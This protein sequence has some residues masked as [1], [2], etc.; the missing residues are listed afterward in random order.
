MVVSNRPFLHVVSLTTYLTAS[1]L[2]LYLPL[3][4]DIALLR[5]RMPGGFRKGLYEVL[6]LGWAGTEK[7]I[8]YLEKGIAVMAVTVLPI[9]VSVHTVASYVFS[10]TVQPMWH[11][12]I[13]GPYFVAGAIFSWGSPPSSWPWLY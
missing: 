11:S 3:I 2:Y 1:S 4:P 13:F 8:H 12:S 6:A 7:Q 9:A 5:D 10:M